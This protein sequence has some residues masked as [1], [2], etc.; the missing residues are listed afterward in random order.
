MC[1]PDKKCENCA[2]TKKITAKK[3]KVLF[4]RPLIS[5]HK[6][7]IELRLI[8][9]NCKMAF[10]TKAN[11]IL[12]F[13]PDILIVP[14]CAKP[15]IVL[16]KSKE[17]LP[18][19]LW[20]GD[21]INKGIGIFGFNGYQLMLSDKYD[22][23]YKWIVPIQVSGKEN[24]LLL[25]VWACKYSEDKNACYIEQVYKALEVYED[26]LEKGNVIIAGD[27]NSNKIWDK[28]HKIGNHSEV[29]NLLSENGIKSTYHE[30]F[31]E[32]QGKETQPTHYFWHRQTKPFHIDY[33]FA[34]AD[35]MERLGNVVVGKYADW[36]QK[37]D[38]CP[39]MIDFK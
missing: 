13:S 23:Q 11:D 4:V 34:S 16:K 28:D 7:V 18:E 9:W 27:F 2:G 24:F 21:N 12:T 35:W 26:F 37:S 22:E 31:N 20:F 19:Y 6:G 3:L 17:N 10:H 15:E 36:A 30:F 5:N 38:H 14:E 8:T 25:A 39:V 1:T 29:V 32:E 33:C